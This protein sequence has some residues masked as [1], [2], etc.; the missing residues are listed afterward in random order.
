ML[1]RSFSNFKN[2]SVFCPDVIGIASPSLRVILSVAKN[3]MA[4]RAGPA[5]QSLANKEY[6]LRLLPDGIGMK[7]GLAMTRAFVNNLLSTWDKR[8][9]GRWYP[10][11]I[12]AYLSKANRK[13]PMKSGLLSSDC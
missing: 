9:P 13:A 8:N 5:K 4:L 6:R 12:G 10:D 1:K 2:R 11:E 7:S 3:L